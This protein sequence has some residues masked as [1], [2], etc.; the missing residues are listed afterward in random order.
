[1]LLENGNSLLW[2]EFGAPTGQAVFYFHGI[3]G[4]YLEAE[5]ADAVARKLNIRLITPK[6]PGYG[7]SANQERVPLIDWP[8]VISQLADKLKLQCF[9]VL[10]FSGGGPYALACA[11]KLNNRVMHVS[12]V[13]SLAPFDTPEMQ[14]H[15]N[16][17]FKP[18]YQLSV[19][20]VNSARTAASQLA[21]SPSALIDAL[22]AAM[23]NCDKQVFAQEHIHSHYEKNLAHSIHNGVE[24]I[25]NDLQNMTLPWQFDLKNISQP[26]DVWHGYEDKNAGLP[27]AEYLADNIKLSSKHFLKN[28]GHYF[29]FGNWYEILLP[30]SVKKVAL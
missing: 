1:M 3:P 13:S 30:L 24:G 19:T 6:R 10:G 12:L 8:D 22:T 2:T 27:I 21:S 23:P 17:D 14:E 28:C 9:S 11:D 5:S 29:L 16:P 4:S 18:L 7:D 20:D 15:L 25:I 26:V